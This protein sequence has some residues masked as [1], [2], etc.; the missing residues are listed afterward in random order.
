[1]YANLFALSRLQSEI[2]SSS[3]AAAVYLKK[4]LNFPADRKVYVLGMEGIESELDAV[5]IQ[6]CGGTVSR[7]ARW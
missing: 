6:H 7:C 5:G 4:V 3:Y 2:F 1:M